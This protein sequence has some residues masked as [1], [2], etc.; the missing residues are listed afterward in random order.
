M[1]GKKDDLK[2][3]KEEF[4]QKKD[5]LLHMKDELLHKKDEL[6]HKKDEFLR[7]HHIITP[8]L[9]I[10]KDEAYTPKHKLNKHS[11]P[12]DVTYRLIKDEMLND[13]NARQNLATFCQT[14]MEPEA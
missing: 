11:I 3:K 1:F 9:S 13:G 14:Y 6:I 8:G 4:L 5:E 12:S 2:H 7:E 10:F